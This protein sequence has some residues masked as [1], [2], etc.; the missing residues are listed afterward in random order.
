[1]LDTDH[2]SLYGRNHPQVIA[3]LQANSEQIATTA[4]NVEEQVKRRLAQVAEAKS[5]DGS[6]LTNAY[7]R[8]VETIMLL[9]EFQVLKYNAESCA[10]YQSLKAQ[11]IK[12]GTQDLRIA[13]ITLAHN[14]ILVT[15][16]LQDFNQVPNLITQKW[17]I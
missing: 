6:A 11:R 8:L 9:S 14:G 1:M 16:N 10:I 2:L 7:Q 17:S 3:Q 15:I 5:K 13:S 4:I 12:V